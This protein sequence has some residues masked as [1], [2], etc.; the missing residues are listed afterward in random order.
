MGGDKLVCRPISLGIKAPHACRSWTKLTSQKPTM[1]SRT[2]RVK[3][4]KR[5]IYERSLRASNWGRVGAM[6][7]ARHSQISGFEHTKGNRRSNGRRERPRNSS[8]VR[9]GGG[10]RGRGEK[11][12][13]ELASSWHRP[14]RRRRFG[15]GQV[16][17]QIVPGLRLISGGA[18]SFCGRGGCD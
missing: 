2:M 16:G 8:S 14:G 17:G 11:T 15:N 6:I 3:S 10:G 13:G 1:M 7:C 5:R 12:D 18:T 9:R 4:G